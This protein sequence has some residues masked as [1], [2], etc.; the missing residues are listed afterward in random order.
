MRAALRLRGP[1]ARGACAW[2]LAGERTL[3]S[4]SPGEGEKGEASPSGAAGRQLRRSFASSA[5]PNDGQHLTELRRRA[6]WSASRQL[7]LAAPAL[8]G[9]AVRPAAADVSPGHGAADAA[10]AV[11]AGEAQAA[12]EVRGTAEREGGC[13]AAPTLTPVRAAFSSLFSWT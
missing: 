10:A 6:G 13:G 9:Q 11:A 12:R 8:A 1:A 7:H 5:L 4:L 2:R 3:L